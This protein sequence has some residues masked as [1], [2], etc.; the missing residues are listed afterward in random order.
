MKMF[1]GYVESSAIEGQEE[2]DNI[3]YCY[4]YA[5][6]ADAA[7][8]KILRLYPKMKEYQEAKQRQAAKEWPGTK[9]WRVDEIKDG[10]LDIIYD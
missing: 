1:R 6:N 3:N 9:P 8:E 7:V 10:F 5:E 4:V 2:E